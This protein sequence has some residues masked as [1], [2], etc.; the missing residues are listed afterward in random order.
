[1]GERLGGV[2]SLAACPART[3]DARARGRLCAA[4]QWKA[5][6][7]SVPS[8]GL[9]IRDRPSPGGPRR[10]R[11]ETWCA[12]SGGGRRTP[13][14]GAVILCRNSS[15]LPTLRSTFA[16]S[17]SRRNVSSL[18]WSIPATCGDGL[19]V[20]P[21]SVHGRGPRS[22]LT[23]TLGQRVDS[24]EEAGRTTGQGS[25]P[26]RRRRSPRRRA[27]CPAIAPARNGPTP[28]RRCS[29]D[30][31]HDPAMLG[32]ASNGPSSRRRPPGD[33]TDL[34][35][36]LPGRV[37]T[38]EI[39][40]SDREHEQQSTCARCG[41]A[42][43]QDLG[44]TCPPSAGPP[45]PAAPARRQRPPGRSDVG[46]PEVVVLA[47][48][49]PGA[50]SRKVRIVGPVVEQSTSSIPAKSAVTASITGPNELPSLISRPCPTATLNPSS[51]AREA[52]SATR[53]VLP[54]RRRHRLRRPGAPPSS[55]ARAR[56][57]TPRS[58]AR[59]P[60]DRKC[61]ARYG[62]GVHRPGRGWSEGPETRHRRR[63]RKRWRP[64]RGGLEGRRPG[65][66]PTEIPAGAT[67]GP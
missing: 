7:L 56:P 16:S 17:R 28:I 63:P 37:P 30:R 27:G 31:R 43:P 15:E 49:R 58:P 40:A 18:A 34:R 51:S 23:R 41:R 53:V 19:G 33:P 44:S 38:M 2:T 10:A 64:R 36:R 9:R 47:T 3:D 5:S 42:R 26:A 8:P 54:T 46:P 55:P 52:R 20:H 14:R 65:R 62:H 12:R 21:S 11:H 61:P 59:A 60:A 50:V 24:G 6:R 57:P 25:L 35:Q 48:A 22:E 45:V 4:V 66:M 32:S 39:V 13:P 67:S 1:M 29:R